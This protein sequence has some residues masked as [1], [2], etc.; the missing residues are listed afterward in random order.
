[1]ISIQPPSLGKNSWQ[2]RSTRGLK[3][4][5]VKVDLYSIRN[6]YIK[7]KAS[8]KLNADKNRHKSNLST[9][10]WT[11]CIGEYIVSVRSHLRDWSCRGTNLADWKL[12][13]LQTDLLCRIDRD[14]RSPVVKHMNEIDQK[15]SSYRRRMMAARIKRYYRDV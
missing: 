10:D 1:M 8:E 6:I 5:Y 7:I 2:A 9:Q 12:N 15:A 11:K 13:F 3:R 4:Q 14:L